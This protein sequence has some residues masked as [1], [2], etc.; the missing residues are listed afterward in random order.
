MLFKSKNSALQ[1]T[2]NQTVTARRFGLDNNKGRR[3]A[4][5]ENLFASTIY[6]KPTK[7]KHPQKTQGRQVKICRSGEVKSKTK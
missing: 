1:L 6:K 7:K 3:Y 5:V 4:V 2:L